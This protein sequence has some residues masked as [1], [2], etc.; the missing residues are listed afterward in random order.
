MFDESGSNYRP[1]LTPEKKTPVIEPPPLPQQQ[2][3]RVAQVLR[4]PW[5]VR[6]TSYYLILVSVF[7]FLGMRGESLGGMVAQIASIAML[8]VMIVGLSGMRRWGAWLLILFCA[9]SVLSAVITGGYRIYLMDS[10]AVEV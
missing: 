4:Q 8:T 10:G 9:G 1:I 2:L 5:W 6:L 3:E 7:R